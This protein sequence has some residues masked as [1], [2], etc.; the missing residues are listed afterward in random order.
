M[1]HHLP[2]GH[3]C[4]GSGQRGSTDHARLWHA[5]HADNASRLIDRRGYLHIHKFGH[6]DDMRL[7][8]AIAT[9]IGDTLTP[10]RAG[11]AKPNAGCDD[12]GCRIAGQAHA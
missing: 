11:E 3:R 8:A 7:G 6:L 1:S 10:R 4:A 2:H 9:L 12:E 5:G